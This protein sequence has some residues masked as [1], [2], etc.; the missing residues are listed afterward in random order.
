M[1]RIPHEIIPISADAD[2]LAFCQYLV[3]EVKPILVPIQPWSKSRSSECFDNVERYTLKYGGQRLLGWRPMRWANIKVEAEA[4]AIWRSPAGELLDITP[5][6]QSAS[7]FLPDSNMIYNGY[8]HGNVRQALTASP[9]VATLIDV[10]NQL[11]K[12]R[13]YPQISDERG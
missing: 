3:P 2:I 12:L 11:D 4:N 8:P 13:A 10:S 5:C 9:L 7:L 1:A 6:E